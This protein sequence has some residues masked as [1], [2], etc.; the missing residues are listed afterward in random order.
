MVENFTTATVVTTDA[1]PLNITGIGML[2]NSTM[3]S[4]IVLSGTDLVDAISIRITSAFLRV[5]TNPIIELGADGGN[6]SV[7]TSGAGAS[8]WTG[9]VQDNGEDVLVQV[10]GQAGKTIY[11]SISGTL[12]KSTVIV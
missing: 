10:A 7:K 3:D 4:V 12:D 5:G 6:R 9:A 1:T 11:W 2:P 8:S